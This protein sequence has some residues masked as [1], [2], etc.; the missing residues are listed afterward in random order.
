MKND[1][2]FEPGDKVM[3]V[4]GNGTGY[5]QALHKCPNGAPQLGKVYCVSE[6]WRG[7]YTNLITLT[8]FD[9]VIDKLGRKV[10]FPA[11]AF[12]KVDEIKLILSAIQKKEVKREEVVT[13]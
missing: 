5:P 9:P 4:G 8:G 6:C 13:V 2:W 7:L 1:Q 11:F 3:R 12:R 10:G